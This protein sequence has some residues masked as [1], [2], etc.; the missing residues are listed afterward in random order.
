MTRHRLTVGLYEDNPLDAEVL[1]YLVDIGTSS[2]RQEILRSFVRS[3]FVQMVKQENEHFS[4]LAQMDE[5]ALLQMVSF[6]TGKN[7]ENLGLGKT[8]SGTRSTVKSKP[9]YPKKDI[10]VKG[11]ANK[12]PSERA[13]KPDR[14][15]NKSNENELHQ[16]KVDEESGLASADSD[17]NPL[18]QL[19]NLSEYE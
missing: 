19:Q 3:G 13:V 15:L 12:A 17:F 18:A 7:I 16:V 10:K 8:K 9:R 11:E 1:E 5:T 6:L 2:K 4:Y 14:N